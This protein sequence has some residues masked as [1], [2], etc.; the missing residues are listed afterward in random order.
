MPALGAGL[1]CFDIEVDRA[2]LPIFRPLS[3]DA[4]DD[5][6]Q[7][8]CNLLVPWSNR[9]SGGGF[10]F[11]NQFYSIKPTYFDDPL[12]LHGN[13]WLSEWE[14][15]ALTHDH[16]SLELVSAGPGPFSY[17][18]QVDYE[19]DASALTVSLFV[20]SRAEMDLPFGL[21]FHPWLPRTANTRLWAPA[22]RVWLE[23][24][25][26]LPT[27]SVPVADRPDWEFSQLR[28]LPKGWINNGFVGWNRRALVEWPEPGLTLDIEASEALGT[29]L[30]YSPTADSSFFCFEPVSHPV[31]AH[32]LPGGPAANGL[33]VLAP[34]EKLSISCRFAPRLL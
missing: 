12:P 21:G 17:V 3:V 4:P 11:G 5:P 30:L 23:D 22:Q 20:E 9:I 27:G 1:A 26:H 14:L 29:Y 32:N 13:G 10:R 25:R 16:A 18:A 28:P 6:T 15:R 8:A 2:R 34:G 24:E 31:D 33:V 7:L 19:L